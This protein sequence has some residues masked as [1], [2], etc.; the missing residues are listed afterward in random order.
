M[1]APAHV[2]RTW[3]RLPTRAPAL[4]RGDI[5]RHRR[6]SSSPDR[7]RRSC[8]TMASCHADSR[9]LSAVASWAPGPE[10]ENRVRVHVTPTLSRGKR[11]QRARPQSNARHHAAEPARAP[12]VRERRLRPFDSRRLSPKK[13]V[14]TSPPPE[15][16]FKGLRWARCG[17][18][19]CRRISS[20]RASD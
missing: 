16:W 8:A 11:V 20:E 15:S 7:S 9:A 10:F 17:R 14:E 18:P 3:R 13:T 1:S 4:R 19:S 6:R 12:R 5:R 2:P